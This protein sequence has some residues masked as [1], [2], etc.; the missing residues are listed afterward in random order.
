MDETFSTI[1]SAFETVFE[2]DTEALAFYRTIT[3]EEITHSVLAWPTLD[4]CVDVGG[5]T[6]RRRMLQVLER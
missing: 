5:E 6:M 1:Q 4:W 3:Q 2:E